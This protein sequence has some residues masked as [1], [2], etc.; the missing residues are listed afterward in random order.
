M[1]ASSGSFDD[2]ARLAKALQAANQRMKY[3]KVPVVAAAY[4][5][6][7]GGG[8]EMCLGTSAVQAA[9]ETYAGLVEVGMGLVPGGGGCMNLLW[10]AMENIPEGAAVDS[11]PSSPR[12]SRTS[13]SPRWRPAPTRPS[14]SAI[15]VTPTAITFDR[16]R[17]LHDA[18]QRALGLARAAGTRRRRGA[19]SS[20]ARA[21]SPPLKMMVLS[22]MPGARPP[23]TTGKVA[24][25]VA[26]ILC[27]GID[28]AAA[29]VS[30]QRCSSSR[31]RPSSRS[32]A[33]RRPRR[34]CSTSS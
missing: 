3:A 15:S 30:E 27:G 28:G 13:P 20:R 32:A 2:I 25:Q 21:A 7:L 26:N 33:R 23:S 16:A 11:Y 5:M 22:L 8:L 31:S 12:C 4:G 14:S 18:K 9:A 19:T 17:L 10:R 34:G 1:A 29:P 6:A 24:L